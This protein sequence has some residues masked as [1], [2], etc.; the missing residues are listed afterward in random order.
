[1]STASRDDAPQNGGPEEAATPTAKVI[2]R[3]SNRKL[4][5]TDRSKYVTLDEIAKMIKA[6]E[7][8]TIIDNET[9]EDLTS[10]TLTQIIYEEEKRESRMP[11][12]MLRNLIQTGGTTLQDLFDRSVKSPVEQAQ[13][14]VE[15]SVEELRHSATQIREAA[16]RSVAELTDQAK[17]MLRIEERKGE[18]FKKA[19]TVLF[20]HLDER[21][22]DRVEDVSATLRAIDAQAE[23]HPDE[24]RETYRTEAKK[25]LAIVEHSEML[26]ARIATLQV[27]IAALAKLVDGPPPLEETPA[28]APA[29]DADPQS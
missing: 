8:V 4:Y 18:E 13:K 5:D 19:L 11:L 2:K 17:K 22:T 12:G 24:S 1:M 16:T 26:R 9:K 28:E 3:Y 7:E 29:D 25:P 27:Q 15:K 14:S 10:V 6:G 21:L 20:D 23:K